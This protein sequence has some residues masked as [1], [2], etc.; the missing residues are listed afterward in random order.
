MILTADELKWIDMR[1]EIYD[2]KYQEIYDEILDHIITAIEEKR[3]GGDQQD[4][5]WLFQEVVDQHF[6]GFF[7]VENLAK[8]QEDIYKRGI[9]KLWIQNFKH[10]LNWPMLAF[11]VIALLLSFELPDVKM[12]QIS[13]MIGC[14]LLAF[15][16]VIATYFLLAGK[17]KT[18]KGKKSILKTQIVT[19]AA[20]P[21]SLLNAIIYL[22]QLFVLWNEKA[23]NWS[24]FKHIPPPVA[25]A[26]V[27][28]FMVL[29]LTV[30]RFCR[31]AMSSKVLAS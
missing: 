29:N 9:K 14:L 11:I 6:K 8:E 4:I 15:S 30:I 12:V 25:M 16:P 3:K 19:R 7:G 1:M 10:L 23:D 17:F 24:I 20:M 26:L 28:F 22:P 5:K 27:L 2:I 18:L 21:A 31:Q 13:L